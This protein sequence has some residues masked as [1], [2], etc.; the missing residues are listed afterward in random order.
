MDET[1]SSQEDAMGAK[2]QGRILLVEDEPLLRGLI[3]QFLRVEG[4]E[5]V[6][7][8]D[9]GEAINQFSGGGEFDLVLLD[10]NLPVYPGVEVARHIRRE[11]PDQ[12]IIICSAAILDGHI[13][14]L[15]ALGVNQYLSKPY[16]PGE[17]L[18]RIAIELD[19]TVLR[20]GA[21]SPPRN[22]AVAWRL[23]SPESSPPVT[24]VTHT[25]VKKQVID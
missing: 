23:D 21:S 9:G 14:A 2:R 6:E 3:A 16:H 7:C 24:P 5:V 17:L 10:L 25:L 8:G 4:F 22:G 11:D 13:A 1:W 19:R 18:S 12:A 20:R 15:S